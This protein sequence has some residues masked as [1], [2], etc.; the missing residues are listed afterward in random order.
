[1]DDVLIH[2]PALQAVRVLVSPPVPLRQAGLPDGLAGAE[3]D[4]LPLAVEART[5]TDVV[6]VL[7]RELDAAPLPAAWRCCNLVRPGDPR[8]RGRGGCRFAPVPV[9]L[10]DGLDAFRDGSLPL[11]WRSNGLSWCQDTSGRVGTAGVVQGRRGGQTCPGG[12][13]THWK[14]AGNMSRQGRP[15]GPGSRRCR[16]PAVTGREVPDRPGQQAGRPSKVRG[17]RAAL[18]DPTAI[19]GPPAGN[20]RGRFGAGEGGPGGRRRRGHG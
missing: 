5:P 18:S 19:R 2:R 14:V 6:E 1:L 13:Q 10:A 4:L 8:H 17:Y 9:R 12:G 7:D 15:A 11:G 20:A 16:T 3:E